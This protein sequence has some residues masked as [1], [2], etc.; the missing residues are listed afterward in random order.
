MLGYHLKRLGRRQEPLLVLL[1]LV[2]LLA[3]ALLLWRGG[4]RVSAGAA[5]PPP[6]PASSAWA[7]ARVLAALNC[8]RARHGQPPLQAVAALE[9]RADTYLTQ[10]L[11]QGEIPAMET[12]FWMALPLV[13]LPAGQGD[14]LLGGQDLARIITA[15]DLARIA[16]GEVGI[17]VRLSPDAPATASVPL[18]GWAVVLAR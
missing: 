13:E 3:A 1:A 5:L 12:P 16:Q 6:A 7:P 15:D 11:R 14:C 8:V 10:W 9:T 18:R 2:V 4:W 17:A